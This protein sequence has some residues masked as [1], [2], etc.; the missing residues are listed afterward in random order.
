[1]T[2]AIVGRSFVSIDQHPVSLGHFLELLFGLRIIGI[3]VRVILHGEFAVRAF[4][5][6]F[7]AC[8]LDS[9]DLVVVTFH[10]TGGNGFFPSSW[11]LRPAPTLSAWNFWLLLPSPD[12]ASAPST[13]NHAAIHR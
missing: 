11:N 1:M 8:P 4:D 10:V 7:S 2:E 6:L 13:C 5:F 9:Q 3:A 12:E